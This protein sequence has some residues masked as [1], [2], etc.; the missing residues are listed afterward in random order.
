MSRGKRHKAKGQ[1]GVS[2]QHGMAGIVDFLPFS[3]LA[4]TGHSP[5]Q[6]VPPPFSVGYPTGDD[7]TG[8]MGQDIS[9][10]SRA[11]SCVLERA[12]RDKKYVPCAAGGAASAC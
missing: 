9:N 8:L 6:P 1:E 10:F 4:V 12:R 11:K 2:E 5:C 7:E 3:L